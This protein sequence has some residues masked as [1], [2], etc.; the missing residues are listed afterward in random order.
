M[1]YNSRLININA[2]KVC[3]VKLTEQAYL[4]GEVVGGKTVVR[5]PFF[6]RV[7]YKCI[8][9]PIRKIFK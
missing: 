2:D 3:N 5:Q 4:L 9:N 7:Y 8:K 1:G 6:K